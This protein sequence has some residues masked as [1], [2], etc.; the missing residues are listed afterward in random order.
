MCSV[1]H[2]ARRRSSTAC[3]NAATHFDAT[4]R[5]DAAA[6]PCRH[7]ASASR[8]PA[9]PCAPTLCASAPPLFIFKPLECVCYCTTHPAIHQAHTAKEH[10]CRQTPQST[11]A[12]TRV[13][14]TLSPLCGTIRNNQRVKAQHS[15]TSCWIKGVKFGLIDDNRWSGYNQI[16]Y[17][18]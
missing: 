5:F 16:I 2:D 9:L 11:T 4:T 1:R 7:S 18:N 6:H 8:A 17:K 12:C 14:P 15:M 13:F 3:L 10:T